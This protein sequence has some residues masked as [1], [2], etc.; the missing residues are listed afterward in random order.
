MI[1]NDQRIKLKIKAD[2][3]GNEIILY[4]YS[5][6]NLID[7]GI[8]LYDE[9]I[10]FERACNLDLPGNNWLGCCQLDKMLMQKWSL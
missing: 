9:V 10:I 5:W 1:V 6:T 7:T 4:N 2:N 8:V 3:L